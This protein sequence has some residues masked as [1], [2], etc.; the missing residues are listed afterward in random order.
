M[1]PGLADF[2]ENLK[3]EREE[4][5]RLK[6]NAVK[7]A[8]KRKEREA[9][10]T[11]TESNGRTAPSYEQLGPRRIR[12]KNPPIRSAAI[13]APAGSRVHSERVHKT[14]ASKQPPPS[15]RRHASPPREQQAYSSRHPAPAPA[16]YGPVPY[17][18]N[19][20]VHP[21]GAVPGPCYAL[22]SE[23]YNHS[24]SPYWHPIGLEQ[25]LTTMWQGQPPYAVVTQTGSE[26]PQYSRVP[27]RYPYPRPGAG[28]FAYAAPQYGQQQQQQQ[29]TWPPTNSLTYSPTNPSS[30]SIPIDPRLLALSDPN[31]TGANALDLNI[32]AISDTEFDTF[33]RV[34]G[35]SGATQKSPRTPRRSPRLTKPKSP[36]NPRMSELEFSLMNQQ[37]LDGMELPELPELPDL[38]FG[39]DGFRL[40]LDGGEGQ[41]QTGEDDG[42]GAVT[43][44]QNGM[45]DESSLDGLF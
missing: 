13:H 22:V 4:K 24:H 15:R 30:S 8:R 14:S 6:R 25:Q 23:D 38:E 2:L 12:L 27:L 29:R 11:E 37:V 32:P 3:E 31:S 17:P 35:D 45:G 43:S 36:A 19:I 9:I 34:D 20:P 39:L 7:A 1:D 33:L 26:P 28:P 5:K 40:P 16:T 10:E 41:L 18:A 21:Q 42:D 44:A